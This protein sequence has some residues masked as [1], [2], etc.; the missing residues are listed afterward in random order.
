MSSVYKQIETMDALLGIHPNRL[1]LLK[2]TI[3][4]NKVKY[5]CLP[6]TEKMQDSVLMTHTKLLLANRAS[7]LEQIEKV[8][9]QRK[10]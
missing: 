10:F 6:A 1:F 4:P 5:L 2:F 8:N 7:N 3:T 9:G